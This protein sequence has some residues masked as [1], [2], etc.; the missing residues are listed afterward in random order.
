[1]PNSA[2]QNAQPVL[3]AEELAQ[4]N[5]GNFV[6]N[7]STILFFVWLIVLVF[8]CLCICWFIKR[9]NMRYE[10]LRAQVR[11]SCDLYHLVRFLFHFVYALSRDR[12]SSSQRA[13]DLEKA[14]DNVAYAQYKSEDLPED[15]SLLLRRA[16]IDISQS[17]SSSS[18]SKSSSSE[19][20]GRGKDQ[21]SYA[22]RV[23]STGDCLF[24]NYSNSLLQFVDIDVGARAQRVVGERTGRARRRQEAGVVVVVVGLR[25]R[26]C[27]RRRE[28]VREL[29]VGERQQVQVAVAVVVEG[30]RR[31][32]EELVGL[33]GRRRRIEV[34]LRS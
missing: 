33:R 12:S 10:F 32:Q 7:T 24:V 8:C 21:T 20:G 18:T 28:E 14:G 6:V 34:G 23:T 19:L 17:V 29:D 9:S 4:L 5:S 3:P 16:Q 2:F 31:R 22:S 15:A 25:G 1:M 26:Q 11:C 30:R 27:R 13:K